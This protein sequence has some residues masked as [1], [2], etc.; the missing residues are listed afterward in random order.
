MSMSIQIIYDR[1]DTLSLTKQTCVYSEGVKES[2]KNQIIYWLKPFSE[3]SAPCGYIIFELFKNLPRKLHNLRI[4][5]ESTE[6]IDRLEHVIMRLDFKLVALR[7]SCT[8]Q[9]N[10]L[11][12]GS[13]NEK[14]QLLRIANTHFS[15]LLILNVRSS[16]F[17]SV[18]TVLVTRIL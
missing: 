6:K 7:D 1:L 11:L 13:G 9:S 10:F 8:A 12:N 4:I 18:S 17:H 2:I 3:K 5:Q 16:S 14:L 15:A